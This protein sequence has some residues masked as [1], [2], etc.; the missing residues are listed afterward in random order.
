MPTRSHSSGNFRGAQPGV[1]LALMLVLAAYAASPAVASPREDHQ[2]RPARLS[3]PSFLN[4]NTLWPAPPAGLHLN[5]AGEMRSRW[6]A[7]LS[8]L[9]GRLLRLGV[10]R[11]DAGVA[12]GVVLQVRGAVLQQLAI[13]TRA[14][15]P[16]PGFPAV[17]TTR[18]A[19]DFSV[20]T[21]MRLAQNAAHTIAFGLRVE[22]RLPNSTQKK[23]IGTNTTEVFLAALLSQKFS[24]LT[25]LAETGLGILTAPLETDE[26]NDV[27]TYG[28]AASHDISTRVQIA[29]EINGYLTT[30]NLIPAG[31]EARGVL[32]AGGRWRSRHFEVEFS[33]SRG[34]TA[35][36]GTW[37]GMVGVGRGVRF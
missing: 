32:R 12:E 27:L 37:G 18:D 20:A 19:G 1:L 35:N 30:R 10:I 11:L 16:R 23:G 4:T 9:Q 21:I 5:L 24:R 34:L 25:L 31:T 17:G 14:S 6:R 22:T 26:Q 28:L 15:Q 29:A 2:R 8:G 3:V 36:E 7:P 33:L 13:D